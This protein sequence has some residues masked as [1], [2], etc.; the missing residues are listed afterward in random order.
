MNPGKYG[1][2]MVFVSADGTLGEVRAVIAGW[3]E[4]C[5]NIVKCK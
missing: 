5:F 4:L 2:K 3:L 1:D